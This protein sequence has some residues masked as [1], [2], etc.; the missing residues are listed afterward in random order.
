MNDSVNIWTECISFYGIYRCAHAHTGCVCI[1]YHLTVSCVHFRFTNCYGA[2]K[3]LDS[4]ENHLCIKIRGDSLN[5][6][7]NASEWMLSIFGLLLN[8]HIHNQWECVYYS[9]L[10]F[11]CMFAVHGVKFDAYVSNYRIR[12]T[13]KLSK[14]HEV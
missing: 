1:Q 9:V 5:S 3:N 12:P 10:L 2:L 13:V 6:K 4:I 8:A 7:W 14:F 11:G